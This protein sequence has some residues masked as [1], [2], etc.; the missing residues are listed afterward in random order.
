MIEGVKRYMDN[1]SK[2]D[3]IYYI[4]DEKLLEEI[5]RQLGERE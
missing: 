2:A 1:L 5:E 4:K 3:C